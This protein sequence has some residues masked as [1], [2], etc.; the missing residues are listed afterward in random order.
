MRQLVR[1]IAAVL[2]VGWLTVAAVAAQVQTGTL[3]IKV[4]DDQGAAVPGA[5]VTL[6]SPVL[7][8][9]LVGVTDSAGVHR[10]TALTVGTY[11]AKTTLTGFQTVNREGIVVVQNS[12]VSL[13][14]TLKVGSLTEEVTV[15]ASPVVDT[16]SATVATNLDAMLLDTTPGGKDIWSIL[17]YKIPGLVFDT[18]DVG[19]NQAGLQRGVHVARHA[20]RA[21]RAA[22]QRRQRGRSRRDR[23][24]DELLRAR[25]VRERPGH[26]PARRTSRWARPAR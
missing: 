16:K 13:D 2:A 24:L 14:V 26:R 3:F 6:T 23:L 21:E 15:S 5:T 4:V 11:A 19:G 9:P 1:R 12:T 18:P 22:R 8:R 10:F 20:E 25:D 17:E 7:P